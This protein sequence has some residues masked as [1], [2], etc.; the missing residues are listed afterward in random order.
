MT[1]ARRVSGAAD[2]ADT[3]PAHLVSTTRLEAFSDGVLAIA[4]TLLI[5]EIKVPD[6]EHGR[7][8]HDLGRLWPSYGGF[9]ISFL[10]I[11]VMWA[12][13]HRLFGELEFLDHGLLYKNLFLL[14]AISFIPFP[15]ALMARYV[16]DGGDNASAAVGLYG[17]TM[18]AI[19]LGYLLLWAHVHRHPELLKSQ[20][21]AI[22]PVVEAQ[23]SAIAMGVYVAATIL[24]FFSPTATLV[25]FAG[26]VAAYAFNKSQ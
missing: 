26:I 17:L 7:L 12:N 6:S 1:D 13:H 4:I 9:V 14:G 2:Q 3:R 19:S 24:C 18:I 22:R 25:I 23:R 20:N 21:S 10:T 15:T 5:L 16:Q 11:G 8:W